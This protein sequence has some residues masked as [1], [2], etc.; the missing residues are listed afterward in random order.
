MDKALLLGVLLLI[1]GCSQSS[2]EIYYFEGS[3][4]GTTYHVKVSSSNSPNAQS[5]DSVLFYVDTLL[6]TYS[7]QSELMRVNWANPGT[8][9]VSQDLAYV[10][11]IARKIWHESEGSFDPTVGPLAW[12][13]GFGPKI[14]LDT[15][16]TGF[17]YL[18]LL[19]TDSG[20]FLIKKKANVFLDFGGIA[21]GYG[22]DKLA[23][24]LLKKGYTDFMIEVGGE[25]RIHG[26]KPDGSPWKIGIENPFKDSEFIYVVS[27]TNISIA[28]SG[29]YR[30]KRKKGKTEISHIVS[31]HNQHSLT[32]D[33]VLA[34]FMDTSC[35]YADGWAT[36]LVAMGCNLAKAIILNGM[37]QNAIVICRDS[38]DLLKIKGKVQ[39]KHKSL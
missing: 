39:N 11:K 32:P 18:K 26:V 22:V 21:K 14:T 23:W 10:F 9:S 27:D 36:A 3:V 19:E 12:K 31:T 5:I 29:T 1:L 30:Q 37:F 35:T 16:I 24:F 4:M 25:V 38:T 8:L 2:R 17:E 20:Y 7:N 6:T 13:H 33:V 28:T 15:I 34:S